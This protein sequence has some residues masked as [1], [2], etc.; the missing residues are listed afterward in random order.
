[1]LAQAT[2]LYEAIRRRLAKDL[3]TIGLFIDFKKAYDT[4]PHDV[5]FERVRGIGVQGRFMGFVEELYANSEL[6]VRL[7]GQESRAIR[8]RRGVR[9]GCPLSPLLFNIFINAILMDAR[10]MP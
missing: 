9:Q 10:G 5:L 1:M 2:A 7:K 6:K 3:P 4:V 8:V